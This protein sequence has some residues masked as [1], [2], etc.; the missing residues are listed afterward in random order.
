MSSSNVNISTK[1]VEFVVPDYEEDIVT[2][3]LANEQEFVEWFELACKHAKW[4]FNRSYEHESNKQFLGAP[5]VNPVTVRT[6][7]YFCNH[8]GKPQKNNKTSSSSSSVKRTKFN[9]SIKIHCP[10]KIHKYLLSD[11]SI[12][13]KYDWKHLNHD[14]LDIKVIASSLVSPLS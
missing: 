5:L 1:F 9:K 7:I 2:I 13:L 3:K 4:V 11:Y 12:T 8:G 10:T 14:P 6:T